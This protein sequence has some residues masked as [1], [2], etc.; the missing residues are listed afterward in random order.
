MKSIL[1]PYSFPTEHFMTKGMEINYINVGKGPKTLVF[2]H[3]LSSNL[4][5]WSK[6]ISEL[7]NQFQCV[8][9]DLPG[10]GRSSKNA[11]AYTPSFYA[12]TL[13]ALLDHLNLEQVVLVGHSMGGQ[14]S[15][16]FAQHY[17][18]RLE[19]LVLVAPA[20]I[21]TF[22]EKEAA[23]LNQ[24]MNPE[25]VKNTSEAQIEQNYKLNFYA[26]P[27]DT[28]TMIQD[29]KNIRTAADF[30]QHCI[31][32]TESVS[33]MLAEP[34][35]QNLGDIQ[36]PVLVL[37]GAQDLLIPNRFLHPT[38]TTSGIAQTAVEQLPNATMALIPESGHFVQFEKPNEVNRAILKFLTP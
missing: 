21:E 16:A 20:G 23:T 24:F 3:G 9:L 10:F 7:Q 28:E 18:D 15:I 33:G 31:A 38:L 37:F 14:A 36:K 8:A 35:Y 22:T 30:D 32:I 6:N 25:L 11:P 27:A 13:L 29:R 4:E 34:V 19:K 1:A 26:M 17:P 12:Q 5:A 2:V